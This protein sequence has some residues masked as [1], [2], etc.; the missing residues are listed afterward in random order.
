MKFK[1][2]ANKLLTN[3]LVLHIVFAIAFLTMLCYLM[4]NRI[5]SIVYFVVL[6]LI[7]SYF[8]K[9]M[10]LILGVPIILVNLFVSKGYIEGFSDKSNSSTDTNAK[11]LKAKSEKMKATD[12]NNDNN[13]NNNNNA[14]KNMTPPVKEVNAKRNNN[15]EA[16]EI[17]R[18][19]NKSG[20]DIDYASTVED[21]YDELNK[22]IG[23]DGIKKLTS[24]TQ[25]LMQ[26]QLQLAEAM[27]GMTPMIEQMEPFLKTASQFM[28]MGGPDSGGL[29]GI[30]K[31]AEQL[32]AKK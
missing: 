26:Q 31:M 9:N 20:F 13:N 1:A 8:S 2:T 16:F 29:A 32:T 21:A 5:D 14:S 15:E 7:T 23:G 17:K 6:A 27:K 12:N 11:S 30:S 3:K 24:D 19:K 4:T 10:I 18:N 25:N 22:I 28:G